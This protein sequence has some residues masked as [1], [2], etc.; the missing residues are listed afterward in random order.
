MCIYINKYVYVSVY[1]YICS[2]VFKLIYKYIICIYIYANICIYIIIYYIYQINEQHKPPALQTNCPGRRKSYHSLGFRK[3]LS[4]LIQV[5]KVDG[6]F[7][8]F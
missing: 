2:C 4:T 6:L 3:E 1:I 8:E 5:V 7:G